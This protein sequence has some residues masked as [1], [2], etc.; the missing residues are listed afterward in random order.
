MIKFRGRSLRPACIHRVG[1]RAADIAADYPAPL[2]QSLQRP[3]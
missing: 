3:F 2:A 1:E